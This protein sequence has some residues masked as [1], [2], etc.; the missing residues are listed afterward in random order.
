MSL[1]SLVPD[2]RTIT[3]DA[4]KAIL[5]V[6]QDDFDVERKTDRSPLTEADLA[7]HRIIVDG[8]RRLPGGDPLP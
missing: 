8:L 5:D 1:E 6:Y 7:A 2:L 3:L 4:A